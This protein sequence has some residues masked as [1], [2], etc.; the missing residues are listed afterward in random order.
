ML[1]AYF[2]DDSGNFWV[3][4]N[5]LYH[6]FLWNAEGVRYVRSQAYLPKFAV[7]KC[8]PMSPMQR[9]ELEREAARF[10]LRFPFF[11]SETEC[12]DYYLWVHPDQLIFDQTMPGGYFYL[13]SPG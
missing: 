4:E 9:N 10:H 1:F 12:W 7:G 6:R 13:S 3:Y 5:N 2:Q 8:V 11:D